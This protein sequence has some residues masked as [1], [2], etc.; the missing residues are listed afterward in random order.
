ME[1]DNNLAL[2]IFKSPIKNLKIKNHPFS[3]GEAK[4]TPKG[5]EGSLM[6]V[7]L[8]GLIE[9][10]DKGAFYK[11]EVHLQMLMINP[12]KTY[13]HGL[14]SSILMIFG[15]MTSSTMPSLSKSIK[16]PSAIVVPSSNV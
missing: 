10:K 6:I 7:R 16:F 5:K 13:S 12:L 3:F 8:D 2:D 4:K 15:I 11:K 1:L 14:L 9:V